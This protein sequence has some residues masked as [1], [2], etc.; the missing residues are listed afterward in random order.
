MLWLLHLPKTGG[1]TVHAA[2]RRQYTRIGV[3]RL[4]GDNAPERLDQVPAWRWR[5]VRAVTGHYPYRMLD[6]ATSGDLTVTLVRHPFDRV[7]SLYY[8][9][10]RRADHP[11][12]DDV[13]AMTL[14]EFL[15]SDHPQIRNHQ[16]SYLAPDLDLDTA[17][18]RLS[19]F[20][21]VGTVDRVEA[22]IQTVAERL[23]WRRSTAKARNLRSGGQRGVAVHDDVRREVI[24]RNSFDLQLWE[25]ARR[26]SV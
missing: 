18:E 5:L 21:V 3:M 23:N 19:T 13:S 9:I 11:S 25:M 16:T 14:E 4:N 22:V 2:A 15:L 8:D 1:T 12:H 24:A 10:V 26:L 20:D 6:R 17:L 7:V